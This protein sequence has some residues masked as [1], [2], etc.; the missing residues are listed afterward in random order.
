MAYITIPGF[1]GKIFVPEDVSGDK[2][3]HDCSDCYSCQFCDDDR[4]RNCL[5]RN[6][7]VRKK[8]PGPG[9]KQGA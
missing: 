5:I 6:P 2:K 3:K 1:A 9:S 4:C 7:H 8:G